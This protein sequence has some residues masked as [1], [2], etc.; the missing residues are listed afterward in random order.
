MLI[1]SHAH[2]NFSAYK[3]DADE[4]IKRALDNDTW[5]INVGSQYSTSKRAVEIA[6]KY[7]RGVYAV[8]G[9][10]PLHLQEMKIDYS[11]VDSQAVFKTRA[12]EF[13]CD[14]YRELAKSPKVVAIGEAGLDYWYRPKTKAKIA[15][16]KEKQKEVFLKQL[17]LAK[18]LSLPIVLHCRLAN[19][20][21][22]DTF[23]K[24]AF[25]GT[26]GVIHCFAGTFEQAQKYMELGFYIGFT[27]LIFK[28]IEGLPEWQEIIERIPLEKILVETDCPYLTPPPFEGERNEPLYVKYIA[29]KVAEIKNITFEEVAKATCKNTREL[30]RI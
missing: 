22:L 13:D 11:E 16:F 20:D 24:N 29:Q 6:Q 21:L 18:E 17:N 4:A 7:E 30:F 25:S 2:V 28:K 5:I 1:D 9:L 12:E 19:D 8:I 14:K 23:K 26:K 27:G 15:E 10:H 3:E